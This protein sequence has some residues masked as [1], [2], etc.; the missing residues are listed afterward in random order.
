MIT[1]H[2]DVVYDANYMYTTSGSTSADSANNE[3]TYL[4][5]AFIKLVHKLNRSDMLLNFILEE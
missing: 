3:P 2:K 1:V 5:V 4:T